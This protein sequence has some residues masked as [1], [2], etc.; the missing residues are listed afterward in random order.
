MDL[1]VFGSKGS[2][3]KDW[4]ARTGL[5]LS[6]TKTPKVSKAGSR[7]DISKRWEQHSRTG[8]L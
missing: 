4:F 6:I 7:E 5:D 1:G 8:S 2:S 3:F